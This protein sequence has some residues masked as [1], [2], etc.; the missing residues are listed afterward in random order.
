MYEKTFEWGCN[1]RAKCLYANAVYSIVSFGCGICQS[2]REKQLAICKD[3][4]PLQDYIDKQKDKERYY[5]EKM[6]FQS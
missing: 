3:K 6:G 5:I 4:E 2:W 1:D